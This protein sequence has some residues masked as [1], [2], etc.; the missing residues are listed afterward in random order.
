MNTGMNE[1][2]LQELAYRIWEAEGRPL[3]QAERHWQMAMEQARMEEDTFTT[4][5]STSGESFLGDNIAPQVTALQDERQ[6]A[7]QN[8]PLDETTQTTMEAEGMNTAE[9]PLVSS[10]PSEKIGGK[11]KAKAKA[12]SADTLADQDIS[13]GS[14]SKPGKRKASDNI[15]V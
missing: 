15:L 1:D 2:N 14:R 8:N 13:A 4:G 5:S 6:Y 9:Q 11:R 10:Q 7:L 12:K 3:G